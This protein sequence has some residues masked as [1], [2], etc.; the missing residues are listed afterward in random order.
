MHAIEAEVACRILKLQ[1]VAED[2][3]LFTDL[4]A[5]VRGSLRQEALFAE[6]SYP[7]AIS[8]VPRLP[9]PSPVPETRRPFRADAG[10]HK[11]P[12]GPSGRP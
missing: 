2:S 11:S 1:D 9:A 10:P 6:P 3:R 8:G 4:M 12:L 7:V 5:M